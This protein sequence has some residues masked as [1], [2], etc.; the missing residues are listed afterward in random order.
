MMTAMDDGS[1]SSSPKST[2]DSFQLDLEIGKQTHTMRD[3]SR[4][5]SKMIMARTELQSLNPS[6][7]PTKPKKSSD[8]PE[9]ESSGLR[10]WIHEV[11]T[12]KEHGGDYP[13]RLWA[14]IR[15]ALGSFLTFSVLIF[16][17]QQILGAV[18]I[19]NIF[20]HSNIKDSFGA[21]LTSVQGFGTS[22]IMTTLLS[23]P[24]GVFMSWLSILEASILLPFAVAV[25]SFF[26]MSCP[27]LTARNLMILVMYIIVATN[28]REEIQ[29]W[30][31]LGWAATYL[32]GLAVAVLMNIIPYYNSSLRATHNHLARLEQD[33]T[34]LLVQCKAYADN[35][36][37]TPGISRAAMAS[38][39]L[40][41]SRIVQN[42]KGIKS[43][44]AATS[45]ELALR[46]NSTGAEDLRQWISQTEKVQA[47]LQQ[48]QTA[49]T[50][51][52]LGEEHQFYSS[53]LREA[54]QVIK[55]EIGPAR[56]RMVDAMISSVAVCHAWADPF[57]K[58]TV[59]PDTLGELEESLMACRHAFHRAMTRAA[60]KLG[61][62]QNAHTPIFAHL[63]RRMS[64]FH[65]LFE[66][67][68]CIVAYL[69][70]HQ[71]EEEQIKTTPSVLGGVLSGIFGAF[72]AFTGP[73]WLWHKKD[74]FRL[75]VK[76]SVG[77]FLASLFVSVPYLW[78]IASPFGVWPGLTIASV[79]LGN[80]GSSFHKASDR[81]FGTLLAAA[82]A[83]LVSDLFPG[84]RDYVKIPAIAV[85][86]F[87][88]VYLRNAEHAYKYTYAATSIGSMLYGSVKNDFN[89]AGYIP[90]RI[91]LIF[92]GIVIF[93]FVELLLFPR[94]SRKIVESKGYE[95]FALMRDFLKQAAVSTQRMEDFVVR[96]TEDPKYY[97]NSLFENPA[98]AFQLDKLNDSLSKLKAES[99]KLKKELES[100]LREPLMGLSLPL[101]PEAFRGLAQ[102]QGECVMYASLLAHA[103]QLLSKYFQKD[104][105][106]IRQV[107]WPHLHTE[108]LGDTLLEAEN[109]C[110]WLQSVFPDGRLRPQAGNSVKTVT[111]AASLR[112][113]QDV[114]LNIIAKWS[115]NYSRF[116]KEKGLESSDPVAVMTLGITTTYILEI[117]RHLQKAGVHVESI[118]HNF[119]A[120]PK[121]N[122]QKKI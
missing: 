118:A 65:A 85:F 29:W 84:N 11:S 96:T 5:L 51:Q 105:H 120:A 93:S 62:N 35:T 32:V 12:A 13:K 70:Q 34:M 31:P 112:S 41:Y 71:W 60:E 79:N 76:T 39:E 2:M 92:C 59:L 7:T 81:L 87:C 26:I 103:L 99:G 53:S 14:A 64:A 57:S 86:T 55:E 27:Q 3:Q 100:G 45:V 90:K 18:W 78:E 101:N 94:S 67:G 111:A 19:G 21:S 66:L 50:H 56:D 83:L 82:Y 119:P 88:V 102:Q 63:T 10:Y 16:P 122:R 38:I 1:S 44:F 116:L 80:T 23:F 54:K 98:D 47:H 113:F 121:N 68:D 61:E 25:L 43:K 46:M 4:R 95:F 33:L 24:V 107:N 37:A 104:G 17:Q 36:G 8:E 40:L 28:V 91:E 110:D 73:E 108:F 89:V 114:R 97:G 109:A 6:G 77:M 58:R 117:C 22:I 20:M 9:E 30:E 52:V 115:E 106:P 49:L 74:S 69:K 75:A 72:V 48:L 15:A 42:V